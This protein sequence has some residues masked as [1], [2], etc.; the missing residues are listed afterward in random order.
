MHWRRPRNSLAG[1]RYQPD[2]GPPIVTALA[3]SWGLPEHER[4]SFWRGLCAAT[5][6]EPVQ[7]REALIG[8]HPDAQDARSFVERQCHPR[9]VV[10]VIESLVAEGYL[11]RATA[12]RIERR[13]EETPGWGSGWQWE[14]TD[15]DLQGDGLCRVI[16]HYWH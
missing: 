9:R 4:M 2:Q 11:T 7:F 1:A 3:E 5:W 14:T 15:E 8:F 6:S 13:L 16:E 10:T 12:S